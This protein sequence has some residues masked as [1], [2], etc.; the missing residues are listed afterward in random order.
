MLSFKPTFSLSSFI[1]IKGLLSSSSL[2]AIRVAPRLGYE[3][4][5]TDSDSS[6]KGWQKEVPSCLFSWFRVGLLRVGQVTSRRSE[7]LLREGGSQKHA[8]S[9]EHCLGVWRFSVYLLHVYHLSTYGS[10]HVTPISQMRKLS[11]RTFMHDAP[12]PAARGSGEVK[13]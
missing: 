6:D 10:L 8:C 4:G 13:S 9:W 2:S 12:L 5:H 3:L 11:L 1:F 7:L